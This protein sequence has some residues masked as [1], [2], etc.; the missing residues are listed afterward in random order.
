[1]CLLESKQLHSSSQLTAAAG[2]QRGAICKALLEHLVL[3]RGCGAVC[4]P[5]RHA[6]GLGVQATPFLHGRGWWGWWDGHGVGG[7]ERLWMGP[8][9]GCWQLLGLFAA[10]FAVPSTGSRKAANGD[11]EL[12]LP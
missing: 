11:Q 8:W 7:V 12:L 5:H 9:G 4:P 10:V 2:C 6:M 1:M 3:Q